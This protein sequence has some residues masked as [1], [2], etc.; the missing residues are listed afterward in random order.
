MHTL[1]NAALS[2]CVHLQTY[3]PQLSHAYIF[4]HT[5]SHQAPPSILCSPADH[6]SLFSAKFSKFFLFIAHCTFLG[7][8]DIFQSST[9]CCQ[10][11]QY[12]ILIIF[13]IILLLFLCLLV[14]LHYTSQQVAY[15]VHCLQ[16]SVCCL[17]LS[18]V[19]QQILLK[20]TNC[21]LV[22]VVS[23]YVCFSVV[24][25]WKDVAWPQHF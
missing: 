17:L 12:C 25:F 6:F 7:L 3:F 21:L 20:E 14:L 1:A 2:S 11:T 15:L 5:H 10:H 9:Q 19:W 4:L 18:A 22:R 8:V 16:S 23:V 13:S 24:C